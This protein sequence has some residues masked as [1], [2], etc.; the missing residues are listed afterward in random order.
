LASRPSFDDRKLSFG[1][2][3]QDYARFRPGFPAEA[4]RWVLDGAA[5]PVVDVADV[6]AG[7]GALTRTLVTLAPHVM[8]FEPDAGMLAE[9]EH[10]LP[11]VPR[12]L[13]TAESLPLADASV[14]AVTVGQAWHW[15]DRPA[16]AAEFTRVLRP[17]GV[18]GLLWNFRDVRVPWVAALNELIGRDDRADPLEEV[19]SVLPAVEGA[20]FEH[21]VPQTPDEV[22]GLMSTISF[23]RLRPDA[24]DVYTAVRELLATDPATAGRDVIDV[25]YVTTTYRIARP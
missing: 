23:V 13:A 2:A 10:A 5:H 15:F 16:A 1:A 11:Q 25:P 6:G 17:G 7:T 22:V 14:D 8:A 21:S 20:R 3:A 9:L 4:A 12:Q 18:I 24:A 19:A